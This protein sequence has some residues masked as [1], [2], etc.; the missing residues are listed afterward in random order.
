MIPLAY[1]NQAAVECGGETGLH[2]SLACPLCDTR[3]LAPSRQCS[4]LIAGERG[5]HRALRALHH[6][7]A[8][9]RATKGNDCELSLSLSLTLESCNF[10]PHRHHHSV[11]TRLLF[12][13]EGPSRIHY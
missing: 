10:S 9:Q 12:D 2:Y 6:S 13:V 5:F 7:L 4:Y 3:S 8:A 1:T 11:P